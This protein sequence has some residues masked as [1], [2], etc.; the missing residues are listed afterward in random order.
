MRVVTTVVLGLGGCRLGLVDDCRWLP[1]SC[2]C[3]SAS[4]LVAERQTRTDA[5]R[6]RRVLFIDSA[7]DVC[8][9]TAHSGVRVASSVCKAGAPR[10]LERKLRGSC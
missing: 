5:R 10:W 4:P 6:W 1:Q 2:V 7:S 8:D 3:Q 9:A